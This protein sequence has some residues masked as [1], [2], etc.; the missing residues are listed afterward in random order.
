M[1]CSDGVIGGADGVDRTGLGLDFMLGG[2]LGG[3]LLGHL[4]VGW[5]AVPLL[6]GAGG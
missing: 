3:V 6:P 1:G 4:A 5:P 2:W